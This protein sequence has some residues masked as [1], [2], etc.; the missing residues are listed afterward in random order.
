MNDVCGSG[1]VTQVAKESR[2]IGSER[3]ES[4]LDRPQNKFKFIHKN[5]SHHLYHFRHSRLP[6]FGWNNK[7]QKN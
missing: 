7:T 5:L 2:P 1:S 3:I 6:C 4:V